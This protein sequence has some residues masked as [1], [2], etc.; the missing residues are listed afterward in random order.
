MFVCER[1]G[2]GF[3]WFYAIR[4]QNNRPDVQCPNPRCEAVTT[5]TVAELAATAL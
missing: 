1:C 3:R 4:V 5:V 2:T